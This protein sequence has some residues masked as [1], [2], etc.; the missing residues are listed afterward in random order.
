MEQEAW[1]FQKTFLRKTMETNWIFYIFHRNDKSQR[2]SFMGWVQPIMW[3]AY[4]ESYA[5]ENTIIK[6]CEYE[7]STRN[8]T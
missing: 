4:I 8:E 1:G 3:A 6:S 2:I 7:I 5:K